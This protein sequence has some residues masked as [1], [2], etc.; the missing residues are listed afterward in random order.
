MRVRVCFG[1]DDMAA[2]L[3]EGL[4][5][6]DPGDVLDVGD[7]RAVEDDEL[8]DCADVTRVE[9]GWIVR[10][11]RIALV[12]EVVGEGELEPE[13]WAVDDLATDG[14][15]LTGDAELAAGAVVG[16]FRDRLGVVGPAALGFSYSE[17]V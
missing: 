11:S 15:L 2:W 6:M 3:A 1:W 10:L 4:G 8:V 17:A 7:G 12:D 13:V 9:G 16:W 14:V 5:T